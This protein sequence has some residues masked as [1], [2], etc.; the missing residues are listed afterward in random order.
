MGK[1]KPIIRLFRVFCHFM[2]L[3]LVVLTIPLAFDVGGIDCGSSYSLTLFGTY[4]IFT[5]VRLITKRSRYFKWLGMVYYYQYLL[6]PSLL[7]YFL[8]Y[9]SNNTSISKFSINFVWKWLLIHSTPIFTILE[10]FC[11]LLLIQAI[12]QTINWLTRYKSDSW[13]IISLICSSL[14]NTGALYF[15]YRIYVYPFT[16]E[17]LSAT[18]LGSILTITI[19]LGVFGMISG[20]GSIIESSLLFAYIVKCIYE[21]FPALSNKTLE[22]LTN[23]FNQ[24]TINFK[25]EIPKLSPQILQK[26]SQVIPFLTANL[27]S[28][29]KTIWEFL[30][31]AI[32]TLTIPLIINLSYRT[33]VFYA[34]TKIIPSLYHNAHATPPRTPRPSQVNLSTNFPPNNANNTWKN[35]T[36]MRLIYAYSPCI[37]I[38]VYTN[39]MFVYS[40]ESSTDLKIFWWNDLEIIVEPTEFWN[41]V[42]MATTLLLYGIEL[43]GNRDAGITNHW[44]VD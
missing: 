2:Y 18:L 13:L 22:L 40:G 9:Y 16:I 32:H 5:S 38:A 19:A 30:I 24:A 41:W 3:A 6:I 26:L 34:A 7:T 31:T 21:T 36:I 29:F 4:F 12:G 35:N 39:L 20:R 27:P 33:G 37:I 42:N 44:K 28:S 17:L 15:L 1:F 8:S 25:S 11:S 14:I 10:G 43:G 23:L